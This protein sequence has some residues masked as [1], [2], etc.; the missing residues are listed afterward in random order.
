MA[1]PTVAPGP[2]TRFATPAGA[3]ASAI[4]R[5]M[6][7]VESGVVSLG[8]STKVL[9]AARAGATFHEACSSG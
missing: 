6:W 2:S 4:S 8:F 5:I 7:I 9:P 3:P 1:A